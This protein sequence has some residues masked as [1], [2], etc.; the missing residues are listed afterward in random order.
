MS[1]MYP[2]NQEME[3]LGK[4]LLYPGV[5]EN[6][7]FTNGD[8]NDTEKPASFIPAETMNLIIDNLSE[9]IKACGKEPNNNEVA[10][11]VSLITREKTAKSLIQR[12]ENG[13][14][15][16]ETPAENEDIANKKYVDNNS[17]QNLL[18]TFDQKEGIKINDGFYVYENG[19]WVDVFDKTPV[20]VGKYNNNMRWSNIIISDYGDNYLKITADIT[21][22]RSDTEFPYLIMNPLTNLNIQT[23]YSESCNGNA[24]FK[25]INS[26]I[27]LLAGIQLAK[28]NVTIKY[29]CSSY[30][31][32]IVWN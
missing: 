30:S 19:V 4:K 10:Q 20:R 18:K 31:S 26:E 21:T 12:D 23:L 25:L 6:G 8:F 15:K 17:I 29:K 7:K 24:W 1:G 9:L 2:D 11:L 32:E 22:I 14:A 28:S 27:G 3:I 13:R 16:I 5:D